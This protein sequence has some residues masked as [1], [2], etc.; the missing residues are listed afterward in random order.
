NSGQVGRHYFSHH[1]GAPVTALFPRDLHNWYGLPAQGVGVDEWADDN[2]DHGSMDFIGGAN[3][4]VHTDRRPMGAARMGTFG[5]APNW[6]SEW[7]K[8]IMENADRSNSAY[9]QKTTLP[10]TFNY[11]DLDPVVKDP[12]GF[13]VTRITGRYGE[14]ELKVA[15]FA[16]EKMEQWY[17]EA[18]AI[19]VS[20]SGL[21]SLMGASTHAYGG[22]RMGDDSASNVVDRWGFSHEA[23][24][25]GVLGG[26]VMGT[27]GARNPTLTVQA[28][29]W[30]SADHLVN[31]WRSI[32]S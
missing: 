10:Y 4:W 11:L 28:L 23:Q 2:F 15:A 19:Q 1:Q 9:L 12:L 31:N 24:N 27:S 7:K 5:M 13:P 30:R 18:G 17:L 22:T 21:G 32:T 29:A 26:S 25:L 3:L 8:F 6:G 20:R 16:Q 14:N